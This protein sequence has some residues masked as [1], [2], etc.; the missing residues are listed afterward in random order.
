MNYSREYNIRKGKHKMKL[1]LFN[2]NGNHMPNK[3]MPL[4]HLRLG[5]GQLD[6]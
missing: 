6:L 1:L 3:K 4:N 2:N 5:I